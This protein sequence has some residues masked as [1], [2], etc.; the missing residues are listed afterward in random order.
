M[1]YILY[2]ACI[3][4]FE[5]L[6]IQPP[7]LINFSFNMFLITLPA[8]T[9]QLLQNQLVSIKLLRHAKVL[10]ELEDLKDIWKWNLLCLIV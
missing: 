8:Q 6:K 4:L 1:V 7:A 2:K 5:T 10:E 3:T 9:P